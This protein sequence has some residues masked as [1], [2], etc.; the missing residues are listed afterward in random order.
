MDVLA[1]W[2]RGSANGDAV[3]LSTT[4]TSVWRHLDAPAS[5]DELVEMLSQHY[6]ADAS[7]LRSDVTRLVAD[8]ERAGVVDER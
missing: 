4:A 5:V 6:T 7:E 3:E 2:L 8:L 1:R